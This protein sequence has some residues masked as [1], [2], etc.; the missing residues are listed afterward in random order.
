M[1]YVLA[2]SML[3]FAFVA[4]G[5]GARQ[6]RDAGTPASVATVPD[7][8]GENLDAA[9]DELDSRGIGYA[10]DAGDEEV[11]LEHLW[12][13]C[14]Q[15]PEPGAHARFVTLTVEHRCDGY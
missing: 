13:V 10:V 7:L 6:E 12:T 8:A 11:V 2:M 14:S 5:C 4:A 3:S 1:R 9:E 15:T